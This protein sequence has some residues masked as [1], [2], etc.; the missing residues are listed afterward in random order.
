MKTNLIATISTHLGGEDTAFT[1]RTRAGQRVDD[2]FV[3][4]VQEDT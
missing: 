1:I 3:K 2:N 4:D